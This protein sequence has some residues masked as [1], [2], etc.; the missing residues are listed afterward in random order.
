MGWERK[1]LEETSDTG[2]SLK[3]RSPPQITLL[4]LEHLKERKKKKLEKKQENF[5]E[6][7]VN[8]LEYIQ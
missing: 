4:T 7:M 8:P 5:G 3:P 6:N 2:A 1:Q